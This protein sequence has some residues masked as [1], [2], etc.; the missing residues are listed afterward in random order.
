MW[1]TSYQYGAVAR[2][3]L[4]NKMKWKF[5]LLGTSNIF[6]SVNLKLD[7]G[8]SNGQFFPL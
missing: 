5:V 8:S 7:F 4:K 1:T 6:F 3:M 2:F